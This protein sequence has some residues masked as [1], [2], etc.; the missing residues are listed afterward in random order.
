MV[1]PLSAFAFEKLDERRLE[2]RDFGQKFARC[3]FGKAHEFVATPFE[4]HAAPR[5]FGAKR[6]DIGE[7]QT[8]SPSTSWVCCSCPAPSALVGRWFPVILSDGVFG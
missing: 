3:A 1:V 4:L 6:K 8:S 2:A 7:V 5:K